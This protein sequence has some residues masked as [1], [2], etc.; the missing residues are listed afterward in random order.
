[1][2]LHVKYYHIG[3]KFTSYNRLF[4]GITYTHQRRYSTIVPCN[5]YT[6]YNREELN[7]ILRDLLYK[8]I[9]KDHYTKVVHCQSIIGNLN[10]PNTKT[11][12]EKNNKFIDAILTKLSKEMEFYE[13]T[14][15][16]HETT[17]NNDLVNNFQLHNK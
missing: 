9:P 16:I 4:V 3:Y 6:C 17:K 10:I 11:V 12:V 14:H 5:I 7:K 8:I 15:K 2:G 13:T 1:M